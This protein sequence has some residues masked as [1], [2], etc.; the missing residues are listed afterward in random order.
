MPGN[1]DALRIATQFDIGPL[2]TGM[3]HASSTVEAETAAMNEAFRKTVTNSEQAFRKV[4]YGSTEAREAI[5]GLGEEMGVRVPRHISSFLAE[6]GGIGPLMAAAFTPIAIVGLIDV[7]GHA[8]DK[9][10]EFR[11]K[12]EK[13][14]EAWTSLH[15]ELQKETTTSIKRLTDL[16]AKFIEI[17]K[18]PIAELRFELKH[19]AVDF[20]QIGASSDRMFGA[21][22]KNIDE[23]NTSSWNPLKWLDF[24]RTVP[25]ST[26]DLKDLAT[27]IHASLEEA[28]LTKDPTKI[29][30]ALTSGM[31]E[32]AVKQKELEQAIGKGA[33]GDLAVKKYQE[34]LGLVRE[35][36]AALEHELELEQ[37]AE[38]IAAE[39]T[40]I[41]KAQTAEKK[42]E[43]LRQQHERAEQ[44]AR[45]FE[46]IAEKQDQIARSAAQLAQEKKAWGTGVE[47][48]E[49]EQKIRA[50]EI[51]DAADERF[52]KAAIDR[53]NDPKLYQAEIRT[54]MA[55][56]DFER[57]YAPKAYAE[58]RALLSEYLDRVKMLNERASKIRAKAGAEWQRE[59]A[60]RLKGMTA[61]FNRSVIAWTNS[62]QSFSRAMQGIWTGIAD[63][64]IMNTLKMGEKFVQQKILM[65]VAT[66]TQK[67]AEAA[68]AVQGAAV[69]QA[70]MLKEQ[71]AAAKAGAGK[72][73][74]A[75]A[76][77]PII[78]PE[79]GAVAAAATFTAIMAFG[80]GGIV[81][82]TGPALLH[83]NEMVLP[84][85]IS[86]AV[87]ASAAAGGPGGG[88]SFEYHDHRSDS[89]ANGEQVGKNFMKLALREMRRR[90]ISGS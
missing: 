70:S 30:A 14:R 37:D 53:A 52:H 22:K 47:L 1:N 81:P 68:A 54:I 45:A 11:E 79:L 65:M 32:A 66:K 40:K 19:I 20:E 60:E 74:S 41:N 8:A 29:T 46:R 27:K 38:K 43:Y 33:P 76:G 13:L 85:H 83:A 82:A 57:E 24:V 36:T 15:L 17:T 25:V 39:E 58:D 10:E 78:G 87:Q 5:R 72:A 67:G 42:A 21:L 9:L 59:Q 80:K 2:Q 71:F 28:L 4:E 3:K 35:I 55:R 31:A 7:I 62:A 64:A 26:S 51:V 44:L 86:Q 89:R 34:K 56:L 48:K 90:G 73:Y 63:N 23:T 84:A 16:Q 49:S 61:D 12:P 50:R 88:H 75:M 77:I 69:T 18:G 6:I